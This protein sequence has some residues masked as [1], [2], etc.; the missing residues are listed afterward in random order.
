MKK[1]IPALFV[2]IGFS[3][4]YSYKIFPAEYRQYQYSG[5][6]KKA[7]VIN[8]ELKKEYAIVSQSGIFT[9]I[10]DS[11][12]ESAVKIKLQ[13]MDRRFTCGEPAIASMITLGQIPVLFP[14]RYEYQFDEITATGTV[15]RKFELLIAQRLW[16][17]DVFKLKKHFTEKAGK[18]LMGNYYNPS[19]TEAVAAIKHS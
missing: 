19:H 4:C 16:F 1:I 8:P 5:E 14:D 12:D 2:I 17:W 13:K 9:L 10:A 3:S 18:A 6:K 15:N 7:F 11:T